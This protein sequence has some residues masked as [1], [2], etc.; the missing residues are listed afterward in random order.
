M[1]S[2]PSLQREARSTSRPRA[3]KLPDELGNL[4]F[5]EIPRPAIISAYFESSNVV[6]LLNHMR[7]RELGLEKKWIV[8]A[9]EHAPQLRISAAVIGVSL[10][11][12]MKGAS[13]MA[14][15]RHPLKSVMTKVL[16]GAAINA[17][18][19]M[20]LSGS[21]QPTRAFTPSVAPVDEALIPANP[22]PVSQIT[23]P[24]GSIKAL[25]GGIVAAPP[26]AP[27]A[28][29]DFRQ[30][31]PKIELAAAGGRGRSRGLCRAKGC[32]GKS[33]HKRGNAQCNKHHCNPKTMRDGQRRCFYSHMAEKCVAAR[34]PGPL[35]KVAY[36][37][38]KETQEH[39][40]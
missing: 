40:R 26:G 9:A 2:F 28:P 21:A 13:C 27:N 7:Q 25:S 34:H 10:V 5:H 14:D 29:I 8:K 12:A 11:D 23:D 35:W 16:A 31:R 17:T 15:S 1:V 24:S 18:L 19:R 36:D 39:L 6:D 30:L 20:D 3:A 33:Q 4:H 22:S 37:Q 32:K 38:W